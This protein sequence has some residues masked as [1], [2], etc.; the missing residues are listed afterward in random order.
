MTRPRTPASLMTTSLPRPSRKCGS[1]ARAREPDERAQ[2]EGV[3]GGGEQVG[4]AAD[5]HRREPGERLVARRLDP[6]PPLD[7]GAGRDR[8][9]GASRS[10]R[11]GPRDAALDRRRVGQRLAARP[12]P[13]RAR[14][15][16]RRRA[17]RPSARAAADIADVARRVVEDARGVEERRRRRTP[18]RRPAAPRRPRPARARWRAGGRRRAGTAR[19]PSAGPS[20]VTSASVD[21]PARPTTRSAAASAA[22]ISSR[23]NGYGR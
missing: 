10:C 5:A 16:R 19:R 7:V 17:G 13:A 18:R 14:R 21:E 2:L 6:D 20:A 4:R 3:V 8:V 15:P 23:R 9:E 1:R 22:S 11:A 12:R